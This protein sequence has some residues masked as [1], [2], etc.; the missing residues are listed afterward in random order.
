[1]IVKPNKTGKAHVFDATESF[2]NSESLL[3]HRRHSDFGGGGTDVKGHKFSAGLGL[4]KN[5]K[6]GLTYFKNE[7]GDFTRGEEFDYDRIQLDLKTKF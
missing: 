7:Y 6:L 1:M 2:S 3:F 4:S 5:T